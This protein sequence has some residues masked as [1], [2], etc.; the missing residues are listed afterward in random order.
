MSGILAGMFIQNFIGIGPTVT[1]I[2]AVMW[3]EEEEEEKSDSWGPYHEGKRAK[4]V[5]PC[6]IAGDNIRK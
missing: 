1:N 2:L 3:E 4:R 6:G 5:C